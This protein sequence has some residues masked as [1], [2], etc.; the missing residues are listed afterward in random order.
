M[1]TEP[2]I[3]VTKRR[4]RRIPIRAICLALIALAGLGWFFRQPVELLG[5]TR[6]TVRHRQVQR[7]QLRRE[8]AELQRQRNVMQSDA[9]RIAAARRAGYLFKGEQIIEILEPEPSPPSR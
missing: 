9:G 2:R 1:R 5:Q 3:R 8:T 7:D 6:E 4:R